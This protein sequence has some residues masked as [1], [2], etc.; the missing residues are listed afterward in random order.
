[1]AVPSLREGHSTGA[2]T[3]GRAQT[4]RFTESQIR[5]HQNSADQAVIAIEY[6]RLF[7]EVRESLQQQ[8]ATADVLK[9][10]SR[11]TLDLPTVLRALTLLKSS[12]RP[13]G[14]PATTLR[15]PLATR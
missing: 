12:V 10:I 7:D 14:K 2:I 5:L 4:R 9:S 11:S 3:V 13:V 8:T 1:M 6:T 15:P